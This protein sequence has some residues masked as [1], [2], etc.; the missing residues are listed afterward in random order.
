MKKRIALLLTLLIVFSPLFAQGGKEEAKKG[1]V[2]SEGPVEISY[3]VPLNGNISQVVQDMSQTE[4]TKEWERLTNTKI[5]FQHV[6]SGN[7]SQVSEGFNILIASGSYPD[8]IEYK[9]T[10]YPGG[11]A[12]ALADGVIMPLNDIFEK[13]CPN[14]TAF[15]KAHPDIAKMI[16]TDDGTYYCFPFLRGDSLEN[17]ILLFSEGWV[18]RKDILDKLGM[19]VPRTPEEFER[20]LRAMKDMGIKNPLVLRKD[21]VAR[22]LAPGF[23]TFDGK[24]SFYVENGKVK[25]VLLEDARKNYL[26]TVAR[27]YKDGLL[28]NDYFATDKKVQA[29]KVLNNECGITWAPGGSGIGTWLP[30]MRK[31]NADVE[32]VSAPPM[33]PDKSRYSKFAQMN[34]IYGNSGNSAAI[35]TSCKNVEA[36][37][38]LLD[39]SY[40][41]EGHNLMC[42]GIEGV[43][44]NWVNGYPQFTD[45]VLNNPEGKSIT[46]VMSMY[47]RGHIHGPF[48]QDPRELEQYYSLPE[49]KDALK[50]WAMTDYGKYVYPPA[51]TTEDEAADLASIM[52]NVNTF[53]EE[54][55]AKFITGVLPIS[56]FG[57]YQAQL[58]KFGL[59][60]A[61]E[62][63]QAAYDRYMKK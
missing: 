2:A 6:A 32:L 50:Y 14:M 10:D 51:S 42:F 58:K 54:M 27:W 22:A 44:Y 48:V 31:T 17:N 63:E 15:L 53:V 7:D 16:S 39:F 55:E 4:N 13:Y 36:A 56:E 26:E 45:F 47:I 30:A 19:E 25:C 18:M 37:A 40:G 23:D 9:W 35:S 28:D 38:K 46:Q 3:W 62:I 52:N 20:V 29:T 61:I 8:I 11:P 49:L 12:A 1:A 34:A 33:T 57:A 24:K 59:E 60:R 5:K 41:E 43:T 21:H